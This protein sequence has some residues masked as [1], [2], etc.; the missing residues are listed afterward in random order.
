MLDL[1]LDIVHF[2]FKTIIE[3]YIWLNE[4]A[5]TEFNCLTLIILPLSSYLVLCSPR[6]SRL[7]NQTKVQGLLKQPKNLLAVALKAKLVEIHLTQKV[8]SY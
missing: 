1:I 3:V 2:L 8:I 7:T 5:F 6:R 4:K